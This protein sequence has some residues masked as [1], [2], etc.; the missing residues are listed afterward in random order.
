MSRVFG[1][2]V[3]VEIDQIADNDVESEMDAAI[4]CEHLK[5]NDA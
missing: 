3:E 5:S 1:D 2:K 4:H